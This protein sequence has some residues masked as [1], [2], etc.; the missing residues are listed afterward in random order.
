VQLAFIHL[1]EVHRFVISDLVAPN[2]S[3]LWLQHGRQG[4]AE[5]HI[6]AA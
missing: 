6:P 2:N 1:D 3:P 4:D 5:P